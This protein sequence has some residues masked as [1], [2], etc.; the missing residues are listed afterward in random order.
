MI[1][2]NKQRKDKNLFTENKDGELISLFEAYNDKYEAEFVADKVT[3]LLDSGVNPNDVA[4]LYR[5]R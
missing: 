2:R 1:K 4:I 5:Q 3:E